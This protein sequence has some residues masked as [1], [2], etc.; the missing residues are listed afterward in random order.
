MTQRANEYKI[1][2]AV[3]SGE[4]LGDEYDV[5]K[6]VL[7]LSLFE[8]IDLPYISGQLVC[9]DDMGSFDEMALMGTEEVKI[10]L[11][12]FGF[13]G[14]VAP[15]LTITMNIVSIVKRKKTTDLVEV[16][17]LN[18]VSPVAFRDQGIK[19]SKSYTGK[20]E[21]IAI[22]ILKNHLENPKI[23]T[24]YAGNVAQSSVKI[25]TP[26]ISPL[27]AAKWLLDRATEFSGAPFFLWQ[28]IYE[29]GKNETLR[30]GD[31]ETMMSGGEVWNEDE[32]LLYSQSESMRVALE[33]TMDQRFVI[34]N[35]QSENIANTMKNM[36]SGA[37]GARL[38][39]VDTFT[40][41]MFSRH[42]DSKLMLDQNSGEVMASKGKVQNVVDVKKIMTYEGQSKP[43]HE[44]DHRHFDVL[45]SYGT[46]GTWNSY[47]DDP[48]QLDAMNKLRSK[49]YHELLQ[50]NPLE[51]TAAGSAF[52][53]SGSTGAGAGDVTKVKVIMSVAH[54]GLDNTPPPEID[55][56]RSGYY[57][58][59]KCRHTFSNTLHNV[60]AQLVKLD[61]GD[62]T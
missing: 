43:I 18:L 30:I 51:I 23:S 50:M 38:G 24:A 35:M 8:D 53:R 7:E 16:Y 32:P 57:L 60:S 6:Y 44:W 13:G 54:D 25:I 33:N 62:K 41:Q 61:K 52:F 27:E 22:S 39:S 45:T 36:S 2:A 34:K 14:N 11:S 3:I 10:T 1:D 29:Q 21:D 56:N 37:I 9:M 15:S 48:R 19:I 46:Y 31:L 58:I 4:R 20:L 42:F 12:G 17:Q 26:Y 40:G 55:E 47:H 5:R 28:S 59:K 49:S